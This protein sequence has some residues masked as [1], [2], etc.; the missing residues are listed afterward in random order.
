MFFLNNEP[1]GSE[2]GFKMNKFMNWVF[3]GII[4]FVGILMLL[5]MIMLF[6]SPVM[7]ARV[8]ERTTGIKVT[9]WEAFC[10]DLDPSKHAVIVE[11]K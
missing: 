5:L 11:K 3:C 6:V 8:Y 1:G 2:R 9:Y 4:G 7:E 10:L